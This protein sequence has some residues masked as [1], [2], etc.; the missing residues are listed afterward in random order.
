MNGSS[1]GAFTFRLYIAGDAVNS[2][3]ALA[4]LQAL[5][6]AHLAGR[7][8]IE[9]VDV[10]NE[11]DRAQSD[12][13]FMTPT[14]IK[15]TPLPGRKVVGTLSDTATLMQALELLEVDASPPARP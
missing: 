14:L 5:C 12:G 1:N 8:S 2:T 13:I 7:H 3:H 10:F 15:L 11:P 4:N 6:R 9:I